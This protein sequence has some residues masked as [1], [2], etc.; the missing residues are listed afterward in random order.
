MLHY[1]WL[2]ALHLQGI[3]VNIDDFKSRVRVLA[4]KFSPNFAVKTVL[5]QESA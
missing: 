1:F 3:Y 2:A 4:S 5:N